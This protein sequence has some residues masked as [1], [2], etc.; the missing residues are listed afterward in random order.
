MICLEVI[1]KC[2]WFVYLVHVKTET[3]WIT[4]NDECC[5]VEASR[6]LLSLFTAPEHTLIVLLAPFS[7]PLDLEKLNYSVKGTHVVSWHQHV[8]HL[9]IK[10]EVLLWKL[11][12]KLSSE[13]RNLF[14]R[15]ELEIC[16]WILRMKSSM[17]LLDDIMGWVKG[18]TPERRLKPLDVMDLWCSSSSWSLG[19]PRPLRLDASWSLGPA[20]VGLPAQLWQLGHWYLGHRQPDNTSPS[21]WWCWSWSGLF[22]PG[23]SPESIRQ[24]PSSG[25][26]VGER[27]P[28]LSAGNGPRSEPAAGGRRET[29]WLSDMLVKHWCGHSPWS[30][31]VHWP[32]QPFS[33]NN[34]NDFIDRFWWNYI[35]FKMFSLWCPP[36][37]LPHEQ[38][39][40]LVAEVNANCLTFSP[41]QI[42]RSFQQLRP[43]LGLSLPPFVS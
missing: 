27:S 36:A 30:G 25:L 29:V 43:G 19:S 23:Y 32:S 16:L 14:W 40:L 8:S 2:R 42:F 3:T 39:A 28:W 11:R 41:C 24:I 37:A 17:C 6:F 7:A 35:T 26:P 10:T 15:L 4:V 5:S 12:G 9:R 18:A 20:G 33:T 31:C 34:K 1:Q 13:G 21:S 22:L 38:I